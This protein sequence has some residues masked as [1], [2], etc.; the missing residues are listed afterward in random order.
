MEWLMF[1]REGGFGLDS[2]FDTQGVDGDIG[3]AWLP[4]FTDTNWMKKPRA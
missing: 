4:A 1:Q 3:M 2:G